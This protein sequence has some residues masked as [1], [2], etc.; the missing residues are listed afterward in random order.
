MA[1]NDCTGNSKVQGNEPPSSNVP[2]L[3]IVICLSFTPQG[4]RDSLGRLICRALI[5]AGEAIRKAPVKTE[6]DPSPNDTDN[7]LSLALLAILCYKP[8]QFPR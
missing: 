7:S 3:V 1:G 4:I 5:V 6:P 2:V 8:D